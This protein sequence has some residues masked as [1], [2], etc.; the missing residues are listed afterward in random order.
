MQRLCT[1]ATTQPMRP[2]LLH[3][4]RPR[5]RDFTNIALSCETMAAQTAAAALLP[6]NEC[7][8]A[9]ISY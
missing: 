6:H 9:G 1:H 8:C 2:P 7:I 5:Q 3:C 4:R